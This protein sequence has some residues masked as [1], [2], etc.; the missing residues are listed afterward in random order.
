MNDP[1]Q[2]ANAGQTLLTE[3]ARRGL[4]LRYVTTRAELNEAEQANILR[5]LTRARRPTLAQILDDLYLRRLHRRM[6]GGVWDWAGTY[7][8]SETNIGVPPAQI[9][10]SV[11]DLVADARA[12]I[13]AGDPPDRIATRVHHRL[14]QIHPFPNGNGRHGRVAADYLVVALGR[15]AFTWGAAGGLDYAQ[16]R[17]EYVT[18]LRRA[19]GGGL[20]SLL[21]FVRA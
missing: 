20:D 12:W 19:D 9:A 17:S 13:D 18:A 15:A 7:R 21:A 1:I 11:R 16:L 5:A 8:T 14:V 10:T 4:K 6:F 2:Q 3:E